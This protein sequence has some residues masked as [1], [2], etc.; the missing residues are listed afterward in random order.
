MKPMIVAMGISKYCIGASVA[1]G[2]KRS[3]QVI[4]RC[5]SVPRQADGDEQR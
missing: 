2:A 5:A 4:R 3:D 1:E